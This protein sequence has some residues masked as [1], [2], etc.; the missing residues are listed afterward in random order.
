[1]LIELACF[2][3]GKVAYTFRLFS[4]GLVYYVFCKDGLSVF[5]SMFVDERFKS[6]W[7]F[8]MVF[9]DDFTFE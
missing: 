9:G 3:L 8:P 5:A 7:L 1:M 4:N 6:Q 2:K